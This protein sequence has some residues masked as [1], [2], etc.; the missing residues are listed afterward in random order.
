MCFFL[1]ALSQLG[2]GDC[3]GMFQ[4]T[5]L[6]VFPNVLNVPLET[7]CIECVINGAVVTD[8]TFTIGNSPIPSVEGRVVGGVQVVDD[9]DVTF[10]AFPATTLRCN[11]S[12]L[13][14]AASVFLHGMSLLC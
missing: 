10:D 5:G 4:I 6:L 9:T 13:T 11:S 7:V 2:P 1:S 8:V 12:G 3:I 14:R